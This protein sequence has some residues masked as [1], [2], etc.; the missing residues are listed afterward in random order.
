MCMDLTLTWHALG[1][2][3]NQH[4]DAPEQANEMCNIPRLFSCL[5]KHVEKFAR[6]MSC[7]HAEWAIS[8]TVFVAAKLVRFCLLKVR[9]HLQKRADPAIAIDRLREPS[10]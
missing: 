6:V 8:T 5:D 7:G 2:Q 9:E 4:C 1:I 3:W 10:E